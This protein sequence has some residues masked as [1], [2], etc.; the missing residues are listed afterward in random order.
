MMTEIFAASS[1]HGK[2]SRKLRNHSLNHKHRE[3]TGKK[4]SPSSPKARPKR[5]TSSSNT[6][7]CGPSV[8]APKPTGDIL[9]SN[10]YHLLVRNFA[11]AVGK[12]TDTITKLDFFQNSMNKDTMG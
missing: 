7:N 8:P 10:H 9:H 4:A 2:R 5:R 3:R 1:R 6:T 11:A 12:V